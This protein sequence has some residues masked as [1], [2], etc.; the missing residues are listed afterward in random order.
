MDPASDLI[1]ESHIADPAVVVGALPFTFNG[2]PDDLDLTILRFARVFRCAEQGLACSGV[3]SSDPFAGDP[4]F[5]HDLYD[6]QGAAYADVATGGRFS[7]VG[8]PD[9]GKR[10]T[11]LILIFP[12]FY[13]GLHTHP[14]LL[15][16]FG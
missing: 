2:M 10:A 7:A 3:T 4:F 14:S 13:G 5:F 12:V 11:A 16:N 8:V 9:H 1:G 15:A 6:G